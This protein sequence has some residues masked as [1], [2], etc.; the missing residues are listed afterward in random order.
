[1]ALPSALTLVMSAHAQQTP[2]VAAPADDTLQEVIVT[3][4][5][6]ARPDLDRLE[7]TSI[8]NSSTFDKRGYTDVGPGSQ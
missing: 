8:I 3:G 2:K 1:M 7:P 5:R 4:S 6:I